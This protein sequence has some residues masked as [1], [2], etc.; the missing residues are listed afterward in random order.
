MAMGT[1]DTCAPSAIKP[2]DC[3]SFLEITEQEY[4]KS[5]ELLLNDL[6]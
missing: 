3:V 6:S 4:V 2:I 1:A 5:N